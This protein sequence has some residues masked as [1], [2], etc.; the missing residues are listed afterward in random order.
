MN[1]FLGFLL[2][3]GAYGLWSLYSLIRSIKKLTTL[4]KPIIVKVGLLFG[5]SIFPLILSSIK[6][7]DLK[8]EEMIFIY[9]TFTPIVATVHLLYL[10]KKRL[11][12]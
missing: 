4:T 2:L 11:V 7:S 5:C 3:G 8:L 1:P 10:Y 12:E 6:I 9:I